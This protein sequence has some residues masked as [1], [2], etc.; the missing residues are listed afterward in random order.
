MWATETTDAFDEWIV[1]A[2]SFD[3][4]ADRVMSAKAR[5][6][7][8]TRAR[9]LLGELLLSELRKLAGK[10]QAELARELGMKQPSLS[11]LE[12]QADM[13]I[14]TLK[15]IVEALGGRIIITAQFP[16]GHARLKQ[17]DEEQKRRNKQS[18]IHI[19]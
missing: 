11:K 3:Q 14:S 13:Q 4:L 12:H 18:D 8:S 2:K 6:R 9:E 17:F 7:A 16:R 15:K 10:S 19:L 1:M 5:A